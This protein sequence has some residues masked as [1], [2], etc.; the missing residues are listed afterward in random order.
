MP[1]GMKCGNSR[2]KLLAPQLDRVDAQL[3]GRL[4]DDLLEHPV[5]DLG[6][7]AA[8]GALLVLVRQHRAHAVLGRCRSGT[9]RRPAA[10]AL[11]WWPTPNWM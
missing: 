8:V 11:P 7:E 5:V 10:S 1:V 3:A 2:M 4:V 6:A 9:A